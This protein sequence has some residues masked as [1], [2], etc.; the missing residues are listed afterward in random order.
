MKNETR[1]SLTKED[2][3]GNHAAGIDGMIVASW[4]DVCPVFHDTVPYKSVTVVC[5]PE[6]EAD[7]QYW[8]DYVLGGDCIA[9]R[10]EL[11]DKKVALRADYKCW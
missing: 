5:E 8:L 7:V 9:M 1:L 10:K 6:Q 11:A 4:L 3:W 2:V